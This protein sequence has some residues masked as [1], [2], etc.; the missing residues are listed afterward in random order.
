[1]DL[2]CSPPVC[3]LQNLVWWFSLYHPGGQG[4]LLLQRAVLVQYVPMRRLKCHLLGFCTQ[5]SLGWFNSG[6]LVNEYV[7]PSIFITNSGLFYL[8]WKSLLRIGLQN[9]FPVKFKAYTSLNSIF[10]L[11]TVIEVARSTRLF[12]R[13]YGVYIA[14]NCWCFYEIKVWIMSKWDKRKLGDSEKQFLLDWNYF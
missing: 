3:E 8:R 2:L 11:K 7:F 1:M 10:S 5:K 4:I 13:W 6:V 14:V 9:F 12:D